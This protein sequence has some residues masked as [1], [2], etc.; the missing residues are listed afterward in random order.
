[1]SV[2]NE[3]NAFSNSVRNS[4]NV[5]ASTLPENCSSIRGHNWAVTDLLI[6]EIVSP[7]MIAASSC[8]ARM[9][10][11]EPAS[12]AHAG[13]ARQPQSRTVASRRFM[14]S[15]A[16]MKLLELPVLGAHPAHGAGC[17]AHHHRLGLDHFL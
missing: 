15:L 5:A 4:A 7:V 1:M 9:A 3:D 13:D 10:S 11:A 2:V 12:C 8:A 16:E 14:R 17:R 6:C